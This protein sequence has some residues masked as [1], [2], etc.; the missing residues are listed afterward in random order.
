MTWSFYFVRSSNS[1]NH[2]GKWWR[3]EIPPIL[4]D[5]F[6][7]VS[8]SPCSSQ[9]L[10]SAS[11]TNKQLIVGSVLICYIYCTVRL[12]FFRVYAFPIDFYNIVL[13]FANKQLN[14][15]GWKNQNEEES[16]KKKKW[17]RICSYFRFKWFII[18]CEQWLFSL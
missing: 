8:F 13:A 11:T 9:C 5:W 7:I 2:K 18:S 15:N 16:K 1:I 3:D 10:S 4:I 12:S 6:I 17:E 14:E